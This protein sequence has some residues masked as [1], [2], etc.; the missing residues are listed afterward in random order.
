MGKSFRTE[1]G[2]FESFRWKSFHQGLSLGEVEVRDVEADCETCK[3]VGVRDECSWFVSYAWMGLLISRDVGENAMDS[4]MRDAQ[5][6]MAADRLFLMVVVCVVAT[7]VTGEYEVELPGVVILV[8]LKRFLEMYSQL[9]W[10][11]H[12]R[13]YENYFPSSCF[14]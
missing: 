5:K 1:E 6:A 14:K 11:I 9:S 7:T 2:S 10:E 8:L 4:I 12:H 13:F 3:E